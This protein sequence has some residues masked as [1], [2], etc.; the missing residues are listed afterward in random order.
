MVSRVSDSSIGLSHL[1]ALDAEQDRAAGRP[2][3]LVDR[4]VQGQPL[5]GLAVDAEDQVARFHAG[6]RRGGVV[7][8]ADDFDQA[9]I[10]GDLK[11]KAAELALGLHLHVG[12]LLLVHVRAVGVEAGEHAVQR[13]LDQVAVLD[14][15]DVVGADLL[16]YV[17][18]Q[19]QQMVGV[20]PVGRALIGMRRGDAQCRGKLAQR[21]AGEKAGGEGGTEEKAGTEFHS[22]CP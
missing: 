19:G 17:A 2:T 5:D 20:R 3:H 18:E 14:R 16:E 13:V 4:V 10:G 12:P 8:R 7:D 6:A 9:A 15:L 22:A 1:L 11:A 21:R